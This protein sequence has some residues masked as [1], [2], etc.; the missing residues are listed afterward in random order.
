VSESFDLPLLLPAPDYDDDVPP[1]S[2]AAAVAAELRRRL[3]GLRTVQLQKLLYYCQ[4]HH[5]QQHDQPLFGDLIMAYD[6]GPIVA[7]LWYAEREGKDEEFA[8]PAELSRDALATITYVV[9]TYG[10][11]TGKALIHMTHRESPWRRADASR[12]EG[13]S[14]RIELD[15]IKEWFRGLVEPMSSTTRQLL[16]GAPARATNP[17]RPDDVAAL[18]ARVQAGG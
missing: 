15:W 11:L 1:A 8:Q 3:P 14:V 5:L 10:H 2:T 18:R 4:G 12:G 16:D 6:M 13:G 7:S 9:G 17:A